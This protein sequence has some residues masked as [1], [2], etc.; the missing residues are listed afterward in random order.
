MARI[1]SIALDTETLDPHIKHVIAQYL[2]DHFNGLE[3]ASG[4]NC[5]AER[6]V[7]AVLADFQTPVEAE[8]ER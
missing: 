2:F 6:V 8:Q 7:N 5:D 3:P 1:V 4:C